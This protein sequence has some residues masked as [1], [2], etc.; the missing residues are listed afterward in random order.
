M[1]VDFG[2]KHL[3]G[4]YR[5]RWSDILR[6]PSVLFVVA[7]FAQ[8]LNYLFDGSGA[9][10]MTL[11]YGNGNPFAFLLADTPLLYYILLTVVSIAGISLVTGVTIGIRALSEKVKNKN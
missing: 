3:T 5:P 9:D 6:S 7:A 2:Y 10:F 11:R 1:N 8:S 4:F